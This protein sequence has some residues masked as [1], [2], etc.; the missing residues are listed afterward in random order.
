MTNPINPGK[1]VSIEKEKIS[2]LKFPI[3]DVLISKDE[4][5]MRTANLERAMKLGNMEHNK[6]KI[7][8]EDSDG[9]KQVET[10]VWGVTDKRIILKQGVVIPIHRIHDIK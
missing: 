6:M 9:M 5:K 7:V 8:F 3:S 1:P 2:G 10:T 4:I